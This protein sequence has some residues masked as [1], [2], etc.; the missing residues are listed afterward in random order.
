MSH[1]EGTKKD[2]KHRN[3]YSRIEGKKRDFKL[4]NLLL[5]QNL[6]ISKLF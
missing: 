1:F 5:A 2:K 6:F 3:S 4:V